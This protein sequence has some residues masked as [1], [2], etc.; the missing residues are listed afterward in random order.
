MHV[1]AALE[2]TLEDFNSRNLADAIRGAGAK[3]GWLVSEEELKKG[4]DED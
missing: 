2:A 4:K 1:C 3:A